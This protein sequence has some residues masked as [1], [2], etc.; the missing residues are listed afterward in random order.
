MYVTTAVELENIFSHSSMRQAGRQKG[1]FRFAR[2]C[3]CIVQKC[4]YVCERVC[5][6]ISA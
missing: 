6:C 1:Y 2:K 3:V 4:A 5:V